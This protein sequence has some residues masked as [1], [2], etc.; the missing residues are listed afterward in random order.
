LIVEL[1][2]S[3]F[4][5][6]GSDSAY[7]QGNID[8]NLPGGISWDPVA[9]QYAIT[10]FKALQTVLNARYFPG[11]DFEFFTESVSMRRHIN[12]EMSS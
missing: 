3:G 4:Y 5:I 2:E 6:L 9:S 12:N 1:P 7:L 11:H 10:R 8:M